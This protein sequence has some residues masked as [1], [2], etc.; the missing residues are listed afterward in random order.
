[1]EP[2]V[3]MR[4]A[5][6][7]A[8]AI[9]LAGCLETAAI[10]CA[11]GTVCPLDRICIPG[12]CALSEQLAACDG[13]PDGAECIFTGVTGL[14]AGGVCIGPT[15]G[16]GELD[17]GE[18]CDDG[19]QTSG[20]GCRAD[21]AK[22]ESC[23]DGELDENEVCDDG[24]ENPADGCDACAPTVWSAT[25]VVG[26]TANAMATALYEPW[27]VAIDPSGNLLIA[28]SN[29]HRIV[30]IDTSGVATTVAGS[31][32]PGFSGDGGAATSAQLDTPRGVAVDGIGNVYIADTLNNRIRRV[33]PRGMIETIAGT[34]VAG[35]AGDDGAAIAAKLSAPHAIA[36]DGLGN[37]TIA[38]RANNRV[39]RI[40]V[41]GIIT[42]IAGTGTASFGGDNAAATSAT[43]N[44]PQGVGLDAQGRVYIADTGNQRIRRI[45]TNGT[46]TTIAG[47][48]ACTTSCAPGFSGDGSA[49][50]SAR[51]AAPRGVTTDG[52]GNV[53][54]ADSDNS[55]IRKITGTTIST[56]AGLATPGFSG[57]GSA[58]AGAQ[59]SVPTAVAVG[60]QGELF[61]AD[62]KNHRIRKLSAV[63]ATVAG[64]GDAGYN[65]DG[66]GATSG[67][68]ASPRGTATDASGNL[69]IADSAA[70]RVRC[71]TPAGLIKTVAGTG[72]AGY[73]AT[74]DG[75]PAI[76]AQLRAPFDVAVD[77]A[78]NLYIA[79]SGNHR[80]R[81]VDTAGTITTV[82]GT[83]TAGYDGDDA[84]AT[85]KQLSNPSGLV[86]DG[87]GNLVIA[88]TG[89]FRIRR[90]TPGGVITTIAGTGTSG[91]TGDTA[92]ATAAKIGT[93]Y[94]LAVSGTNLYI[95]DTSNHRI[96]RIDG[97][98]TITTVAGTGTAGSLGDNGA[99]TSAMLSSPTDVAVDSAG[100]LV[101]ADAGNA[102]LRRVNTSQTIATIAGNTLGDRGDGALA[103][104]ALL[105]NPFSV[106]F[107]ASGT[108]YATTLDD[109]RVR[110]IDPASS[111]ITTVAGAT[112]PPGTG[113]LAQAHVTDPQALAPGATLTVI[114]GGS[115]GT[116]ELLRST[117]LEVAAGRYPQSVATG[118]LARFRD[119][120]FSSVGGVAYDEA[121]GIIYVAETSANRISAITIVDPAAV[122]TWTIAPLVTAGLSAPTGL[123]V[124]AAAHQLLVADTANHAIRAIQLPGGAMTT[125]AG[126]PATRGDIGD[127]SAA[128][129]ALLFEPRAIA[130][131]TNGDL[132]I[133]DAGNN[134]VR[135]VEAATGIITTVLGDG[136]PAS[137]GVGAPAA[138][139]PVD[140]PR[141]IVCD[142]YGNIAVTSTSAIRFVGA[143]AAGVVD[144]TGPVSTIY[145]AAPRTTF[146][147]TVTNCLS[148]I[149]V[150][151]PATLRFTD[152]CTGLL[153]ELHRETP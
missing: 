103:V 67:V 109:G 139:F 28:D 57:D 148:G 4:H 2:F 37:L 94:G 81:K 50:T 124:D 85:T 129:S 117:E 40:D 114:A 146:P 145:G 24:N 7:V 83:G 32:A 105:D 100:N 107:A 79:D 68:L 133:A 86:V 29:A 119:L 59:L 16:N 30:R 142:A 41:D 62:S 112:D 34:A 84:A 56:I 21:C 26:G 36:V 141:G 15:C 102:R 48:G 137:S 87:A 96:R 78:G 31:G 111:V 43:L 132:F 10:N 123:Y 35:F 95:A 25:V 135:R 5:L 23:G 89:N 17:D 120:G 113:P 93:A 151:D 138:K 101:I 55:R 69:Y 27:A 110:R 38:D 1:V 49:A 42:T 51:L 52:A 12:G 70:N 150:V 61:V 46:I 126:V 92:A 60:A 66:G 99:A 122:E 45:E 54:I 144:G 116:V 131:C 121:G 63:I 115:S 106:A 73:R 71:V 53:Y 22:A 19:N 80:V 72:E 149:A 76:G 147:A 74:D 39:R 18:A 90:V 98:G 127:G 8:A 88:D 134:R 6:F 44:N 82:A 108:L 91:S 136:V 140:S 58:P 75:A 64:N 128:T 153:V 20:D 104:N 33:D 118:S 47:S 65:G 3:L 11:D 143:D 77:A 125:I 14:C 9:A 97:G 13:V 130:R 152:S